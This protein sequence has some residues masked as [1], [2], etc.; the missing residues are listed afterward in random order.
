MTTPTPTLIA[1]ALSL[2]LEARRRLAKGPGWWVSPGGNVDLQ[3]SDTPAG[4]TE[5]TLE[6]GWLYWPASEVVWMGAAT[7]PGCTWTRTVE[8]RWEILRLPEHD[9]ATGYVVATGSTAEE[10]ALRAWGMLP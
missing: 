10:C 5:I 1:A 4:C 3:I 9:G 2:P 8:G 6:A 7:P